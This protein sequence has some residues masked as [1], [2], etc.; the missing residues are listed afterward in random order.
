MLSRRIQWIIAA[1]LLVG[2]LAYYGSELEG[3]DEEQPE[4]AAAS[5]SAP[6][7]AAPGQQA[8]PRP[9]AAKAPPQL[10]TRELVAVEVHD[11]GSVAER[12]QI[13]AGWQMVGGIQWNDKTGCPGLMMQRSWTAI[14]PDSLTSVG[15]LPGFNWQLTGT[16]IPTSPCPV[17]P[18]RTVRELL[19]ATAQQLH[20]DGQV[21]DYEDLTAQARAQAAAAPAAR[22]GQPAPALDAG[23]LLVGYRQD[24]IE[25]RET[26]TASMSTS[27]MQGNVASLVSSIVTHRAPAGRFDPALAARILGTS[28]ADAQWMARFQQR[29]QRNMERFFSQQRQQ[30]DQWHQRQMAMINARGMAERHAIRMRTNQEVAGIYSSIAASSSATSDRMHSRTLEGIGEYNTYSGVGGTAVQSSIHGGSRVFQ[31]TTDPGRAFSTD[32]P[33]AAPPPGH[34]ELERRR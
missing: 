30:I 15:V 29:S 22:A 11:D 1:V 16:Q 25:M 5:E 14:A 4:L 33:Y 27:T 17:A 21:L 8:P 28:Q 20:P 19:Q 12:L 7:P 31:N 10:D 6:T 13:P 9:A 2:L 34:V 32:A 24:G 3:D 23:R 26:L 18:F